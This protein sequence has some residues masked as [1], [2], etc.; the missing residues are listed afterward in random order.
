MTR[1]MTAFAA[2]NTNLGETEVKWE[3]RSVN[4]RY[5]EMHFRLPENCRTLETQL[6]E[7]LRQQ[8]TRGKIEVS[9]RLNEALSHS[10]LR[11]DN[12]LVE[13]LV[14]AVAEVEAHLPTSTTLS[15]MDILRWPGVLTQQDSNKISD[16]QLL[17]TF[18]KALQSLSEGR[19]RE[20][21]KLNG[22]IQQRLDTIV[23]ILTEL[24]KELPLILKRQETVLKERIQRLV[25]DIDSSRIEQETALLIQKADVEEELDRLEVHVTEV[26][27]ILGHNA[28]IGRRLDFLMQELNREANTL[29]SKSIALFSTQV[30]IDLKVLIEQ[31]REQIQNIE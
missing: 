27:R 24:R 28:P 18:V 2:L 5:L 14:E 1:S 7:K 31:M 13:S 29:S 16:T 8:L 30:A 12:A 15:P 19:L 21:T 26:R 20:G 22:I 11:V 25:T 3:I 6:R 10:A 23:E 9:L 4:S 17:E